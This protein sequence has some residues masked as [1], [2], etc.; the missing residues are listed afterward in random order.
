M[1]GPRINE[2]LKVGLIGLGRMGQN[3]F[4]VLSMLKGVDLSCVYDVDRDLAHRT[5]GPSGIVV[6]ESLEDML[7]LVDAVVIASPTITHAEYVEH[8]GN[9]IKKIFI[10]K[11]LAATLEASERVRAF[12]RDQGLFV[13][14]GFIERYNPAVQQIKRLYD[15]SDQVVSTDFI[16]T[17]K[18]SARIT[19]V[20]VITDLMIHD[21]D[22]ALFLNGPVVAVAAHGVADGPMIDFASALLTHTNGR[23]SRILAS[24]ITDKK[25]RSVQGTCRDMFIDCD[26]LR[27]EI[28]LSRQSEVVQRPG[29]PYTITAIEETLEVR[30]QEALLTQLQAFV[31][32]CRTGNESDVPGAQDGM[33]A[34]AICAQIQGAILG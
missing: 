14:V 30:P 27:K 24:R 29:E 21:I 26:L 20:D 25:M 22:L 5:A 19:D 28:K 18:I 6:A 16:R 10:E 11:P 4:R 34:M 33:A 12:A 23:F 7:P 32:A 3:H 13:Q 31:T 2:S 9:R 8:I 17:N 1:S 15:K